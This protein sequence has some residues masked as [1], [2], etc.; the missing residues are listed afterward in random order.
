MTVWV[1]GL[2]TARAQNAVEA[3]IATEKPPLV[4]L[5]H[6][7]EHKKLMHYT[8]R[9]QVS[10]IRPINGSPASP[11]RRGRGHALQ[12]DGSTVVLGCVHVD[13]KIGAPV[14]SLR[15]SPSG[16]ICAGAERLV[17]CR[18]GHLFGRSRGVSWIG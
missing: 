8:L 9:F 12:P 2:E 17:V 16:G 13:P 3:T 11:R 1:E 14:P 6:N 7:C 18:S 15:A 5:D 10:A 4:I